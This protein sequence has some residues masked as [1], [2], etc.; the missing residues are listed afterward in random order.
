MPED[1]CNRNTLGS[2]V[3]ASP[4]AS[5][6]LSGRDQKVV[7]LVSGPDR[8]SEPPRLLAAAR[9]GLQWSGRVKIFRQDFWI[10]ASWP[11]GFL[12]LREAWQHN[13]PDALVTDGV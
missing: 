10:F 1:G 8:R 12:L 6:V 13:Q 11:I 7:E 9:P 2:L 3:S 5:C 4:G